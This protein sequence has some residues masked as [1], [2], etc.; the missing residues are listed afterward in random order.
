M[1]EKHVLG[2]H[3]SRLRNYAIGAS[4]EREEDV[5][6]SMEPSTYVI[7]LVRVQTDS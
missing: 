5:A 2:L 1:H 4:A 3:K 6:S 7:Q